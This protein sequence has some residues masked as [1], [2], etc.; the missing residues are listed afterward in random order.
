MSFATRKPFRLAAA[1]LL[2]AGLAGCTSTDDIQDAIGAINPF[3]SSKKQLP[4]ERLP[5]LSDQSPAQMSKNKPVSIGGTRNV[6]A[7]VGAGGPTGNDPGNVA[8]AGG[9]GRVWSTSAAD[10]GAGSMT[11]ETV[12][13]FARPVA[14]DG[15]I[16]VYDPN[17]N[18]TA[19]S[20]DG[21]GRLWRVSARPADIDAVTTGGG[22][23]TDGPRVYAAT[24][25]GNVVAFDAASG[26]KLWD[27]KLNEPARG[28]PTVGDGKIF[29]VS[30]ANIIYCLSA[31]D[32]KELWTFNGVPEIGGLLSSANPAVVGGIVVAPF[33]SGEL[34]ALDI[35]T[36]KPVWG[37]ALA[38]AS[39]S[40]AVSGL[41]DIS[42]SPVVSDG[43]VYV[44]G[45]GSRT[46]AI[47]L[48]TGQ[49]LWDQSVGSAHTPAVSGNA[50]FLNDL[51]DNLIALDRKTGEVLWSSRLP[52]TREK[53]KRTNWAGPLL[54]GG[55][56]WLVSNEG[57]MISVDPKSG[58]VTGTQS[59]GDPAMIAPIAVGGK[60]IVLSAG[61][62][63][64]AYN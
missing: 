49:R 63:L 61:G 53:K 38:R 31:A 23:T 7:W 11:R 51:D 57:G 26:N 58:Q 1:V 44:T 27:K 54:A 28:A 40:F 34:V 18:I 59:I 24:G 2:A 45:V 52:V 41:S 56:L 29:V 5:V 9:S 19:S 15:R 20:L 4:G 12:R 39:R 46:A 22:V 13:L 25:Y 60:L 43:V 64:A 10:I 6:N 50:V 30:Q 3:G 37:D 33:T 8:I 14:A 35:K 32:G 21:G 36:G 62:T 55:Q 48:K 42:A 47:S 17:G 16:F